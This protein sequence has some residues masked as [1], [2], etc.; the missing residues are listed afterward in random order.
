MKNR[1]PII[2]PL[3]A[4]LAG[5]FITRSCE[6]DGGGQNAIEQEQRFFDIY[7]EA[8]YPDASLQASGIY[9]L[10]NMEGTGRMPGDSSWLMI[11][12]VA[13]TIP[14]EAVYETYLENVAYDNRS[15]YDTA[16][17]YGTYKLQNGV[18]NK[19]FT[20]GLKLMREGGE[21]TFMFTSDLGF[22]AKNSRVGGYTSLKYEVR[23]LEVIDDIIAYEEDKI[24]A[25]TDT[26]AGVQAVLDTIENVYIYYVI[27]E[28]SDGAPVDTDS[29]IEVAYKGY[30]IDGRV[31]DESA[32]DSGLTFKVDDENSGVIIGWEL[33]LKE[34][35]EG[36]K[37]RIIIPYQLA[38]GDGGKYTTKGNVSIPPYE[39]LVFD[40]NVLSVEAADD[41]LKPDPE[42]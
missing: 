22:G 36:E 41:D 38:Y 2:L 32:E 4:I 30:L 20:E 3:L 25:Y 7:R 23:L 14:A 18:T 8:N 37:G 1:I 11:D 10:E 17:L 27:D 31:F 42:L 21:A 29:T 39:T 9:Y 28:S 5:S 6:D 12:H 15:I 33:G 34:F 26:I 13:Y 40:V 24:L 16:A 35:K 19:G